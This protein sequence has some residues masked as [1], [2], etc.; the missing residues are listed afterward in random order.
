MNGNDWL[1][2]I[3]GCIL[4]ALVM[5]PLAFTLLLALL[6]LIGKLT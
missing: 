4:G 6:D 1:F 5:V 2:I 3:A